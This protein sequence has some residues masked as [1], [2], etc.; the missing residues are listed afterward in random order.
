MLIKAS[1]NRD[2]EISELKQLLKRE[3]TAKQR[4]LIEREAK[5]LGSGVKGEESSSYYIDFHYQK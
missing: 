5:C 1:D 3:L 4:F 2:S